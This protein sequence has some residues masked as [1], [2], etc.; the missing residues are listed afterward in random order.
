M[1]AQSRPP[2]S[3][4][5]PVVPAVARCYRRS[6]SASAL[7]FASLTAGLEQYR[8]ALIWGGLYLRDARVRALL[9]PAR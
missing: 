3:I 5:P 4:T 2:G 9:R 8:P 1:I 6:M 7:R